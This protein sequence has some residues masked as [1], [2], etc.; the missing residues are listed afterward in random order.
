MNPIIQIP[1]SGGPV[2]ALTFDDG[3]GPYTEQILE[4]L[5]HFA[6]R[7]TFFVCGASITA[8][9]EVLRRTVARGHLL[10]NHTFHHPQAVEGSEPFGHFDELAPDVQGAEL[11]RTQEAIDQALG[12]HYP[13][14][15]MRGPGGRHHSVALSAVAGERG[16]S[17]VEWSIDTEDWRQPARTDPAVQ[18]D[19]V[20]RAVE[21]A[22]GVDPLSRRPIL[23]MHDSKASAEPEN[24]VS[25]HRLNTI[26]A[27]PRIIEHYLHRGWTFAAPDGLAW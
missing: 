19:I 9:P 25:G 15:M 17:I 18:D 20:R 27:L 16:L 3:P 8:H 6:V 24:T 2:I 21:V 22:P 11:D 13:T 1:G 12:S 10:G 14:R 7:A 23:L 5:D 4:I 26:A